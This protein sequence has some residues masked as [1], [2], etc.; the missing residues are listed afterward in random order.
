MKLNRFYV[1]GVATFLC[2][3]SAAIAEDGVIVVPFG[4]V[5]DMGHT[6]RPDLIRVEGSLF[7]SSAVTLSQG[8]VEVM[9][10]G[11]FT[12]GSVLRLEDG[13]GMAIHGGMID[14]SGEM[15]VGYGGPGSVLTQT[16]GDVFVGQHAGT[17]LYLFSGSRYE[18]SGG[19]LSTFNLDI[20]EG[21]VFELTDGD[22]SLDYQ[23]YLLNGT[24]Q[25]SGGTLATDRLRIEADGDYLLSG[26]TLQISGE[27]SEL[28][29]TLDLG[30][31]DAT[32]QLVDNAI[33]D[34][35]GGTLLG[36]SNATYTAGLQSASFFPTGF[37]PYTQFASFSSQGLVHVEGTTLVVPDGFAL[38]MGNTDRP[39]LI[40]VEGSLF[41]SSAVTLSQGGVE[42]MPGGE[43]TVGS[44]LRLEDGVGMAIHGGMIDVSGEMRVGY[45]GPGSVLTQT[46]GDVFVGQ[47]AGT[48][49]YLFSGSRYEMSGGSLSTFNL[50]I[51]EGSVFELTDGDVSLDYQLYLLNGTVQQSGGTLA[52]DRLRIEADG[53]YLLS[54]GTLQISGEAE[55]IGQMSLGGTLGLVLDDPYGYGR[56]RFDGVADLDGV[57]EISLSNFVPEQDSAF[58]LFEFNAGTSGMFSEIILPD[59]GRF[60]WDVSDIYTTGWIVMTEDAIPEPA[61]MSLLG[62]GAFALIRR[63]R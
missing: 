27:D 56:V 41:G 51:R 25:Q 21:S 3:A 43:F 13:V 62:L 10:G 52:T 2:L 4:A 37:D 16:G 48:P 47:H 8:G 14:V 5:F 22:V 26:G 9:P 58:Y 18:M 42:V 60:T 24:V 46:G 32:I 20:R 38:D 31:G 34:W 55:V 49:L 15:R 17:P 63:R 45:G 23:L 39:D 61:T 36:G 28:L 12:V 11:E 54:G 30:S 44:V 1:I 57:L 29:G 35:G 50:D 59:P 19:S 33:V 40:R 7:G 53:D 6:D